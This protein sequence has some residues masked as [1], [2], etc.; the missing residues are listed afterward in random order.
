[1]EL[2]AAVVEKL[3]E[4]R[5]LAVTAGLQADDAEAVAA[6]KR[7]Y[8]RK[9]QRAYERLIEEFNGQQKLPIDE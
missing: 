7:R 1:M 9:M 3:E 4:A 5:H 6:T 8:A 2:D